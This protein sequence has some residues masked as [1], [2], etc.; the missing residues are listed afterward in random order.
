VVD[1]L[2][3]LLKYQPDI[4]KAAAELRAGS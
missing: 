1:T 4:E 3:V 2:Y